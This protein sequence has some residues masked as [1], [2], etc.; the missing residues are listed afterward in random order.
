LVVLESC[1]SEVDIQPENITNNVQFSTVDYTCFEQPGNS[2]VSCL[3]KFRRGKDSVVTVAAALDRTKTSTIRQAVHIFNAIA[4]SDQLLHLV[5]DLIISPSS[6]YKSRQI[7]CQKL[8]R[9]IRETFDL[10][11]PLI[12]HWDGKIMSDYEDYSHSKVNRLLILMSGKDVPK[13]LAI[14][15]Q[16]WNQEKHMSKLKYWSQI[17]T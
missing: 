7:H 17:Y 13:L 9:E 3:P 11:T 16:N 8:T 12:L 2:G 15:K 5:A 4:E 10:S 14:L 6:I 1:D